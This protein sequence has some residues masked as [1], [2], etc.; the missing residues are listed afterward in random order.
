[1]KKTLL[2]LYSILIVFSVAS[3]S[4]T[5]THLRASYGKADSRLYKTIYY[6]D[7]GG[8]DHVIFYADEQLY[9]IKVK[10]N[11]YDYE[12][13]CYTPAFVIYTQEM[14]PKNAG[15]DIALDLNN[16]IPYISV[17]YTRKNGEINEQYIYRDTES[18]RLWLLEQK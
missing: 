12:N 17:T 18:N 9:D 7:A 5:V 2:I 8:G 11:T 3:C 15:I 6:A 10:E 16:E 13:D 4:G 1:M 14:L